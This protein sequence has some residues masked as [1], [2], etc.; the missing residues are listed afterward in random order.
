ML[1]WLQDLPEVVLEAQ[2]KADRTFLLRLYTES[3]RF[4]QQEWQVL[5][6]CAHRPLDFGP[7][8]P[9]REFIEH[10]ITWIEL[11][12]RVCDP[13]HQPLTQ[14]LSL[15]LEPENQLGSLSNVSRQQASW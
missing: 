6:I 12:P 2:M 7:P 15:L 5:V 11:Q 13:P 9:V 8:T 10:R 3:G 4:R 1:R 14:A